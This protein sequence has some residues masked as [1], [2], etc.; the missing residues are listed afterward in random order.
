MEYRRP[1]TLYVTF[2]LQ[3]LWRGAYCITTGESHNP[4][5]AS[6]VSMLYE[7]L[8]YLENRLCR[9]R[10]DQYAGALSSLVT[11][12]HGSCGY[13]QRYGQDSIT[14]MSAYAAVFLLKV[15]LP[16]LSIKLS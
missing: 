3:F 2:T 10:E 9:L 8:R 16:S 13:P 11:W 4:Q 5:Y 12:Y 7:C 15:R 1:Y 14:V 6:A